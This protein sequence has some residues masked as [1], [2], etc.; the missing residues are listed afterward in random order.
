METF[1]PGQIARLIPIRRAGACKTTET[2]PILRA[3]TFYYVK[4]KSELDLQ[5]SSQIDEAMKKLHWIPNT[6]ENT[7]VPVIFW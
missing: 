7:I 1:R 4:K 3:R 2:R 5:I 6:F